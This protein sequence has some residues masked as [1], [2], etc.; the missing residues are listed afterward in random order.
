MLC[1]MVVSGETL[2]RKL[3]REENGLS[4][5]VD[6]KLRDLFKLRILF[7]L[8]I[9]VCKFVCAKDTPGTVILSVY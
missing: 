7:Y 3:S 9:S 8:E 2:E 4:T 5:H 1:Y 6:K